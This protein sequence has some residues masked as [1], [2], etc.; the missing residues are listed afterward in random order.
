MT[1][2]SIDVIGEKP[3][4]LQLD[5]RVFADRY[6]KA[7][8]HQVVIAH[9]ANARVVLSSQKSRSQ[10]RGGG[11]KPWRQKGTG[12]ARAGTNNSPL[13]R[14]GGVTFASGTQNYAQKVN[15]KMHQAAMRSVLSELHRQNRLYIIDE[16]ICATPKTKDLLARLQSLQLASVLIIV[17]DMDNNL[18]LAA[19]NLPQVQVINSRQMDIVKLLKYK[20]VLMTAAVVK[21]SEENLA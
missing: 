12:R 10:V 4:Q 17:A 13:W 20:A 14:G 15:K 1:K 5:S 18:Y 16:F 11:A 8:V 19:R 9:Q 21:Q 3:S 7:L 6:N 2:I